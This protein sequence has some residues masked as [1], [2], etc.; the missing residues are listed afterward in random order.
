MNSTFISGTP[1]KRARPSPACSITPLLFQVNS[2]R[3]SGASRFIQ[4]LVV[5]TSQW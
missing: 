3:A 4:G 5:R 2:G 1:R